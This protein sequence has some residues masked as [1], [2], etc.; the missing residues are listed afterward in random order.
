MYV[1]T[2]ARLAMKSSSFSE[3]SANRL[4]ELE[5][6]FLEF[7]LHAV[8]AQFSGAQVKLEHTEANGPSGWMD[9]FHGGLHPTSGAGVYRCLQTGDSS[10]HSLSPKAIGRKQESCPALT[11]A[12]MSQ[13]R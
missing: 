13:Q 9:I 4:K 11:G 1:R 2:T 5:G 12:C 10:A 7:Y 3:R 6:L 8:L